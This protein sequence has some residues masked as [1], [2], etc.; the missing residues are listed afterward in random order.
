[1]KLL[2]GFLLGV[3]AGMLLGPAL[4]AKLQWPTWAGFLLVGIDGFL[5]SNVPYYFSEFF[6][7]LRLHLK[8]YGLLAG[9]GC[10]IGFLLFIIFGIIP[11]LLAIW[12]AILLLG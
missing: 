5:L 3:G 7:L 8:G 2:F 1:M 10:E 9:E 4:A 11:L 12:I 6:A